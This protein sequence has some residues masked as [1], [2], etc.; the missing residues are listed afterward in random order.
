MCSFQAQA[1]FMSG[2]GQS[3]LL[4]PS[5]LDQIANIEDWSNTD[6]P[7]LWIYRVGPLHL[8]GNVEGP[9]KGVGQGVVYKLFKCS[10]FPQRLTF[11][12]RLHS[13]LNP[14]V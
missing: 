14:F 7:G 10:Q 5:G 1:G 13:A 3:F 2:E 11:S 12:S 6:V 8:L 4:P 9:N